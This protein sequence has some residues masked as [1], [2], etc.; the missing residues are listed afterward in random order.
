MVYSARS[1]RRAKISMKPPERLERNISRDA[2]I[3]L[4]IELEPAALCGNHAT[5][6]SGR[7]MDERAL[8]GVPKK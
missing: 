7:R 6:R 5:S 2:A 4:R 8:G 1:R 3:P